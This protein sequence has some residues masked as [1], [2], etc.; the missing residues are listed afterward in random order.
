MRGRECWDRIGGG[1]CKVGEGNVKVE[2][3]VGFTK[4]SW[5][6]VV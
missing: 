1:V 2:V 5:T 6:K 3:F 4:T